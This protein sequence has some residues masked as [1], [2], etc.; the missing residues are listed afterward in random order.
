MTFPVGAGL[1]SG[2][3]R[4]K[5]KKAV[6]SAETALRVEFGRYETGI[7]PYLVQTAVQT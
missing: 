2:E 6:E 7:D 3:H 4:A 1:G 5:L